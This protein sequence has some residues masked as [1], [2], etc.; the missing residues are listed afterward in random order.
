MRHGR[1]P[2]DPEAFVADVQARGVDV[3]EF[4]AVADREASSP[5][6]SGPVHIPV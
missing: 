1:V 3:E 4:L 6:R 2:G 5:R